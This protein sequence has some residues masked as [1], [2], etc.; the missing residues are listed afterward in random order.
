MKKM[1]VVIAC[2][3]LST[4]TP[5]AQKRLRVFVGDTHTGTDQVGE[6][7]FLEVNQQLKESKIY[8]PVAVP[9]DADVVLLLTSIDPDLTT[10]LAG[11]RSAIAQ[12]VTFPPLTVIDYAIDIV[13]TAQVKEAARNAVAAMSKALLNAAKR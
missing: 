5:G 6:L 13:P 1:I 11:R 12:V 2:V 7:F 10:P 3:L 8:T 4:A 9:Q